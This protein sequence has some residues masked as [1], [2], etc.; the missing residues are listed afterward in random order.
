MNSSREGVGVRR[1]ARF[2]FS[3][4]LQPL[5]QKKPSLRF[6]LVLVL[7][8]GGCAVVPVT[9]RRLEA[10][11]TRREEAE[12]DLKRWREAVALCNAFLVSPERKTLPEGKVIL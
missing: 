8:F 6:F 9:P 3:S 4:P 7:G 10:V 12:A 11:T 5:A 1:M 2:Y